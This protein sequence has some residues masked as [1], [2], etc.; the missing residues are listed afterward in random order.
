MLLSSNNESNKL[1][2]N[3]KILQ[4][5]NLF[6][7]AHFTSNYLNFYKYWSNTTPFFYLDQNI[8]NSLIRIQAREETEDFSVYLRQYLGGFIENLVGR[9]VFIKIRTKIDIPLNIK[10]SLADIYRVN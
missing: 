2:Q 10:Q 4:K 9:K 5:K 6:I 7:N 3:I 1:I 8:I